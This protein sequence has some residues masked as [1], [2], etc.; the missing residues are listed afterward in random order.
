MAHFLPSFITRFWLRGEVVTILVIV[1]AC[2]VGI[3]AALMQEGQPGA[4]E[5]KGYDAAEAN[6]TVTE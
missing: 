3:G 2:R 5:S 4:F 6:H 1:D